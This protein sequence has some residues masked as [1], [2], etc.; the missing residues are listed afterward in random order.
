[1][2]RERTF[3]IGTVPDTQGH[4]FASPRQVAAAANSC[5]HQ[6]EGLGAEGAQSAGKLSWQNS[7]SHRWETPEE[8]VALSE[9][10]WV[11]PLK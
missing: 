4:L 1:M 5:A 8:L 9:H 10:V 6:E 3:E 2:H 11:L 7:V